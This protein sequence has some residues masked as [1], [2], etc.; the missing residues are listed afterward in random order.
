MTCI[1]TGNAW[2]RVRK[3][4]RRKGSWRAFTVLLVVG[5]RTWRRTIFPGAQFRAL[6]LCSKVGCCMLVWTTWS[7]P[8]ESLVG[9]V[10][11]VNEAWVA[12]RSTSH[13]CWPSRSA[14]Q[15]WQC[16]DNTS[17]YRCW[18]WMPIELSE[19]EMFTAERS[20]KI[21]SARTYVRGRAG[22]AFAEA[23]VKCF[24]KAKF[25]K[26]Y[27]THGSWY[28][29]QIV[30]DDD[31]LEMWLEWLE[32]HETGIDSNWRSCWHCFHGDGRCAERE[33]GTD[34][35]CGARVRSCV[36][37]L[38]QRMGIIS[39]CTCYHGEMLWIRKWSMSACH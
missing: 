23:A 19:E 16:L 25:W 39:A 27:S 15:G 13:R 1:N 29:F 38:H 14:F 30:V 20:S 36:A 7:I 35:F 12:D 33:L 9:L 2:V 31:E 8:R 21:R 17:Q 22:R 5:G 18:R 4:A 26:I 3:G 6:K 34:L 28:A 11:G 37:G 24:L 32:N 10:D